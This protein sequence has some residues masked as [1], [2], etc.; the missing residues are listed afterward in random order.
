MGGSTDPIKN[1]RLEQIIDQARRFNMPNA[2]IQNV[3]KSCE[4]DKS[5]AKA[6]TVEI[7]YKQFIKF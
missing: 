3:L 4:S 5:Q 2:S 1:L 7:K 6:H